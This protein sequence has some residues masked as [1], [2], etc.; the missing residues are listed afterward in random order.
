LPHGVI[1]YARDVEEQVNLC[2]LLD[3]AFDAVLSSGH[4]DKTSIKARA[5]AWAFVTNAKVPGSFYTG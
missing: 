1:D 4:F 3:V 5:I 2:N